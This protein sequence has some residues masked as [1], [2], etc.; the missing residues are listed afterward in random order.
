MEIWACINGFGCKYQVSTW[1]RI[2]NESGQILKP[3]ETEKGY[4]KIVLQNEQGKHRLRVHRIVAST[5]L[6]NPYGYDCVNH[7]DGNKKNNSVSNLEYCDNADNVKHAKALR[8]GDV[9]AASGKYAR[10]F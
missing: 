4:L 10:R 9:Q 1:G 7:I 2:R 8:R 3:F 6:Y 5:F